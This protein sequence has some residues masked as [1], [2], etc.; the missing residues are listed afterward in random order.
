MRKILFVC[1]GN[2]CRSPTA[3]A[4]ALN[5]VK[6]AGMENFFLFDSAGT[7]SFHQGERPDPRT[8]EV[9]QERGISFAG[10]YSRKITAQDFTDFDL[11]LC[12]DRSHKK[13]LIDISDPKYHAK[14]HLF[15]E[16]CDAKN[17]WQNEVIDPYYKGNQAFEMV[18]DVIEN[19]VDNLIKMK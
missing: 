12:M 14:I 18:Y 6:F 15:L 3:H 11:I 17:P 2:I 13:R 8:M 4:V 19:A 7:E 16:F 5:K 9:G 1:T 10:I